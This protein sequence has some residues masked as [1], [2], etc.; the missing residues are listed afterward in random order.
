MSSL[1]ELLR[2]D[3]GEHFPV[4]S[5]NGKKDDPLVVTEKTD[6]V[7]VEYTVAHHVLD[8]LREERQ[9][10][11]QRLHRDGARI[12]DELV[13]DVKSL[14]APDWEGLRRF[15]FDISAGYLKT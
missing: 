5:G 4:A 7:S 10:N 9:L 3:L 8:M 15:F 14:G 13:F 11:S 2:N 6:Y 1:A 12:I